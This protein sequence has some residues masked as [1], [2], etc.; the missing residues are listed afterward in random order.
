MRNKSIFIRL[1]RKKKKK[2]KKKKNK[3]VK[4]TCEIH[5]LMYLCFEPYV[6]VECLFYNLV[7]FD[8]A[9]LLSPMTYTFC[10]KY[11]VTGFSNC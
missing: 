9:L 11:A 8:R 3:N 2:N 5:V 6:C 7:V 10:S 1:E 4:P